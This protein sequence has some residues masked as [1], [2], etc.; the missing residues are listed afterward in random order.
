MATSKNHVSIERRPGIV[1]EKSSVSD[2]E[3]DLVIGKGHSGKIVTIVERNTSFTVSTQ[4]NVK[5]ADTVTAATIALLRP[6][7]AEV[8][9]ITADNGKEFAF[10]EQMTDALG[11]KVYFAAPYC[12]WQRGLNEHTSGLLRQYWPKAT[13]FK[14]VSQKE[15]SS[16]IVELNNR[17]RKKLNY[18]TPTEL[19]V[20]HMD[21][22]AP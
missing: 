15:V 17:P 21:P 8:L 1:D 18:Q 10:H 14:K 13:D 3:I 2:W 4:V 20:K 9:T 19:M 7:Q 11:A 16:V 22:L 6:F 12:S 5:S